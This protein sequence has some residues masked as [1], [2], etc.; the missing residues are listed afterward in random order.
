MMSHSSISS[1]KH[2]LWYDN[3]SRAL[4]ASRFSAV[5]V[6]TSARTCAATWCCC[7]LLLPVT[8]VQ[9]SVPLIHRFQSATRTL[10]HT[11]KALVGLSKDRAVAQQESAASVQTAQ[12]ALTEYM[13]EVGVLSCWHDR[14]PLTCTRCSGH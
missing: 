8:R 6:L 11:V 12:K 14:S 10:L 9:A 7:C 1:S 13:V 4:W 3:T 2:L 5:R